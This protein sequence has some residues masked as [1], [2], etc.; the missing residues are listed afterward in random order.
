[1]TEPL[2]NLN[3]AVEGAQGAKETG[4]FE[5]ERCQWHNTDGT[6]LLVFSIFGVG[7]NLYSVTS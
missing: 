2:P 5:I 4:I 3:P 6:D 1:M 7:K